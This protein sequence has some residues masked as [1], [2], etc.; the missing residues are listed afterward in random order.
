M[1]RLDDYRSAMLAVIPAV[2]DAELIRALDAGGS[3]FVS[4]VIDHGLGPLW[5]DRTGRDEF[6][7]SRLSAEALFLAQEQ[8]IR[9]IDSALEK[10]GIEYALIKGAANRLLLH[11]SPALRTCY[12]LDV[13]VRPEESLQAAST[14]VAASFSLHPEAKSISRELVL[15]RAGIDVDLHWGL[16]REGRLRVD[17]TLE[18][19]DRRRRIFNTWV[20]SAEDALFV[21]LVHP[22]FAK[23][24][25]G[26]DMGLHRVADIVLWLR[27]QSFDRQQLYTMLEEC[28]V[29]TAAWATL[30][31]VQLL[32]LPNE[33]PGVDE[34]LSDLRP[35]RLRRAWLDRWLRNDLSART[36]HRHWV[37]LLGFTAFLHDTWRDALRAFAGRRRARQRSGADLAAFRDLST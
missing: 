35:G 12:D 17:P 9:D 22:A 33:L 1:S 23:H 34:M 27:T 2:E 21:L 19:L 6:R 37:R 4:F 14:I 7:E 36:S 20:L 15:T 32:V 13:L 30:R 10:T 31:W 24:L 16:L 8:A 5:R 28:G 11:E 29:Q 26:W 3:P 18:M 25:A